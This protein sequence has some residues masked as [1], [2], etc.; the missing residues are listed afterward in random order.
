MSLIDQPHAHVNVDSRKIA[1]RGRRFATIA[2][3][4]PEGVSPVAWNPEKTTPP[5]FFEFTGA[6]SS[7]R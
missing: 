7:E 5:P 3:T 4:R 2:F 6:Y 1:R